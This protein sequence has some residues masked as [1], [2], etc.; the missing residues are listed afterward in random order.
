MLHLDG[1]LIVDGTINAAALVTGSLTADNISSHNSSGFDISAEGDAGPQSDANIYGGIIRGAE[2]IGGNIVTGS[3]NASD[4]VLS[5]SDDSFQVKSNGE[6]TGASFNGFRMKTG[7]FIAQ[8]DET[9]YI[10]F[11]GNSSNNSNSVKYDTE[12]R[13][14]NRAF[15]SESISNSGVGIIADDVTSSADFT[16]LFAVFVTHLGPSAVW[17]DT[18]FTKVAQTDEPN[19]FMFNRDD[20]FDG[21]EYFSYVAIGI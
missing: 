20:S 12:G 18:H 17:H 8:I 5:N 21:P 6:I 13:Y 1:S 14:F 19:R 16:K 2:I 4:V 11:N 10:H 9:M 15:D 7:S 3:N